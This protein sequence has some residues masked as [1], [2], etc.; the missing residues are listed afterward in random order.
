M[1]NTR[2]LTSAQRFALT[3]LYRAQGRTVTDVVLPDRTGQSL[4]SRGLAEVTRTTGAATFYRM[5]E[6]GIAWAAS[7]PRLADRPAPVDGPRRVNVTYRI[8]QLDELHT[9]PC[10]VDGTYT[11]ERDIPA[12]VSLRVFGALSYAHL[13]H[14]V[15]TDAH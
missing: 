13:I 14:V 12:M 2:K 3:A 6:E 9:M 4:V 1:I 11:T 5:S 8:G 7:V 15:L 10:L